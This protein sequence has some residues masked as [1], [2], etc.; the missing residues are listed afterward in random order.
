MCYC[1][2][3]HQIDMERNREGNN[4]TS[5]QVCPVSTASGHNKIIIMIII[6]IELHISIIQNVDQKK[7][8]KLYNDHKYV[9]NQYIL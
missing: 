1:S 4:I 2:F 7:E 3:M 5:L 6:I 8:K 9:T